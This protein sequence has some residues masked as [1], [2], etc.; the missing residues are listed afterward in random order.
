MRGVLKRF[1]AMMSGLVALTVAATFTGAAVYV[2]V[3]EQPARLLLDDR[4][5]LVE[6]KHPINAAL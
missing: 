2:H 3:A 5:L 1:I 4:A 6:W